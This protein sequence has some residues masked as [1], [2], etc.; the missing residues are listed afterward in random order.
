MPE[1]N[2][3]DPEMEELTISQA[4]KEFGIKRHTLNNWIG[5]GKIPSRMEHSDL[6]VPY[7]LVRRGEIT[8]YLQNR[9]KFGRPLKRA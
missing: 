7:R 2:E 5:A 3:D 4:S 1:P 9:R 6:G 8:K